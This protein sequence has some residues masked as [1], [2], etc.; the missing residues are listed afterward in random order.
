MKQGLGLRLLSS[1][2]RP[3]FGGWKTGEGQLVYLQSVEEADSDVFSELKE[4]FS[5]EFFPLTLHKKSRRT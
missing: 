2:S 3:V 1:S 4:T 5:P